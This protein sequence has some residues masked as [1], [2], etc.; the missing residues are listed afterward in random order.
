MLHFL[1]HKS[2]PRA[3][4]PLE[5]IPILNP[6]PV[7]HKGGSRIIPLPNYAQSLVRANAIMV[8]LMSV[9]EQ[10]LLELT[11]PTCEKDIGKVILVA[12]SKDLIAGVRIQPHS[13]RP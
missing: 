9:A 3:K 11:P 6:R 4:A 1:V 2:C 7:E 13:F 5:N 12:D 8:T 10:A